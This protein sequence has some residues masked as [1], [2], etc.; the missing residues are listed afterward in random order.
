MLNKMDV[1]FGPASVKY[2]SDALGGVIHIHTKSPEAHQT[3][4]AVCAKNQYR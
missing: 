3:T 1:V 4:K 2:G